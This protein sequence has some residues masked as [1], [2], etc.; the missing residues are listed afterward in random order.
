MKISSLLFSFLF[1]SHHFILH[2]R[3][4]PYPRAPSPSH[5]FFVSRVL[6]ETC[7]ST[8]YFALV[9]SLSPGLRATIG[10]LIHRL[11]CTDTFLSVDLAMNFLLF[12]LPA[13]MWD[14]RKKS[15]PIK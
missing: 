2:L 1:L 3:K 8:S 15:R 7:V 5:S 10:P 13:G 9:N 14:G 12:W 11:I 4:T 6:Y